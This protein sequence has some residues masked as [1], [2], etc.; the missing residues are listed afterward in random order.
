MTAVVSSNTLPPAVCTFMVQEASA[1]VL[2][3]RCMENQKASDTTSNKL[4]RRTHLFTRKRR[5]GHVDCLDRPQMLT[6]R[7]VASTALLVAA[8]NLMMALP[9]VSWSMPTMEDLRMD[10]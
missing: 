3:C 4:R 1:P 10:N 5:P 9:I 8:Q 2:A 7:V 6:R